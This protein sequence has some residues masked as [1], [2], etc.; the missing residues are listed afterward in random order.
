[1]ISE[2]CPQDPLSH[3]G[4]LAKALFVLRNLKKER[5]IHPSQSR[6][7]VVDLEKLSK[8]NVQNESLDIQAQYPASTVTSSKTNCS[9]S[10][11]NKLG[12]QQKFMIT[13]QVIFISR[14]EL[15]DQKFEEWL[16]LA[17][18]HVFMRCWAQVNGA[19]VFITIYTT[20]VFGV[21]LEFFPF[22][23]SLNSWGMSVSLA[24]G[25]ILGN[26]LTLSAISFNYDLKYS[27]EREPLNLLGHGYSILSKRNQLLFIVSSILLV[28]CCALTLFPVLMRF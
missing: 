12:T 21:N 23:A 13:S 14:T 3:S 25:C 1:M 28:G 22:Q 15:E 2:P 19:L 7:D 26:I 10:S 27:G 24:G 11:V 9:Q 4:L 16:D 17:K 5:A 8:S 6:N 20:A 18:T